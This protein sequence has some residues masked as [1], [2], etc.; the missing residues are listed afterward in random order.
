[1][2]ATRG[3]WL[4]IQFYDWSLEGSSLANHFTTSKALKMSDHAYI[5]PTRGYGDL[6]RPFYFDFAT[7]L[8]T[9]WRLT[10]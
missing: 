1:M 7:F 8:A 2:L 3:L 10:G 6:P 9:F 4:L 5:Y